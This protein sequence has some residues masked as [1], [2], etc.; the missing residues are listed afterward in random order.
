MSKKIKTPSG[1]DT[2]QEPP[3][4]EDSVSSSDPRSPAERLWDRIVHLGLGETTLRLGTGIVS[5]LLVVLVVWVMSNFVLKNQVTP[6]EEPEGTAVSEQVTVP[7]LVVK[8]ESGTVLYSGFSISRLAQIHTDRPA[9]PRSGIIDYTILPGDTLFGI[10][11]KFG[12]QPETLL[13]SN[14]HILGDDPHNIFPGVQILIPPIDG[15]IYFWNTG[16]GLNGVSEFYNVT[17]D[18]IIDWPANNLNRASLGDFA[19]PNIASGTMLFVPGGKGEFTDWLAHYTREEPAESSISGSACGVITEGYIGS[20]TFVWP[21]TETYLSGFDYSPETN[22]R[23]IDIAG[24]IGNPVYAVDAGVVVYSNW[25]ENGYGNLIVVDHGNGWQSVYAHLDNY[26]KYCGDNV[27]QGEQIGMLGTTGNSTGP[28]L[29][30]E[31]RNET[32]GVVNPWDFLQ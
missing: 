24:S 1:I 26:L 10:A 14:R 20:G 17:P 28:H 21:T 11:D 25:N 7:P 31:L 8:A 19:M 16:D 32:Y 4:D 9:Q 27:E 13:W 29:H 15:A 30:F 6:T 3:H 2:P 18:V 22:H 5:V 12:L 23:G